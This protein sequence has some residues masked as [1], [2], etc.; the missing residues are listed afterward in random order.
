MARQEALAIGEHF[1]ELPDPRHS[2]NRKHELLDILVIAL[3]IR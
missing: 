2:K 1:A 3:G